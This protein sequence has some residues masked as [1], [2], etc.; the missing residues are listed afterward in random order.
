MSDLHVQLQQVLGEA[1]ECR[2]IGDLATDK[3]KRRTYE[4]LAELY[5]GLAAELTEVVS[6]KEAAE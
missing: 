2:L 3:G 5:S 6:N 1:A 4:R